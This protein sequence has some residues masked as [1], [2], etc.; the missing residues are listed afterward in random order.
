MQHPQHYSNYPY[1][2]QP[3]YPQPPLGHP[4]SQPVYPQPLPGPSNGGYTPYPG[5][6]IPLGP[7]PSGFDP[8][9]YQPQPQEPVTP[10]ATQKQNSSK[11][12]RAKTLAVTPSTPAQPL[13]SALKKTNTLTAFP[14]TENGLTRSRTNSISRPENTIHRIRTQSNARP[15]SSGT[16]RVIGD[17]SLNNAR[18]YMNYQSDDT[19]PD[20]SFNLDHLFISFHGFNELQL[21]NISTL[22]LKEM[23][24]TI[25]PLWPTGATSE[26]VN[27]TAIVRFHNDPWDM[28]GPNTHIAFNM[29][30]KLFRLC[31]TRGYSFQTSY[32][33]TSAPQLIFQPASCD[34]MSNFFLGFLSAGGRKF[35]LIKAPDPINVGLNPKLRDNLPGNI[36]LD[37]GTSGDLKSVE[38][39]QT[40]WRMDKSH[41][42]SPKLFFMQILR[43]IAEFGYYLDA[44]IPLYRRGPLGMRYRREILVFKGHTP[45]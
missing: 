16:G 42:L 31:A 25:W 9:A 36:T 24:E 4:P 29:I 45:T 10:R 14:T 17:P 30:V 38:L 28:A 18:E 6:F 41:T 7:P 23:Q 27:Y 22:A 1:W 35:T 33:L 11:H 19:E 40:P 21:G 43:I 37:L 39:K 34:E 2:Q 15:A 20:R 3:V 26:V 44:A 8:A 5:H 32:N 13:R 12:R